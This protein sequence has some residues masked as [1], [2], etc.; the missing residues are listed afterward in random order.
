MKIKLNLFLIFCLCLTQ[1]VAQNSSV[2]SFDSFEIT[3]PSYVGLYDVSHISVDTKQSFDLFDK[4]S[5]NSSLY[6]AIYFE[7]L[8]FFIAYSA[9]TYNFSE[10]G[11]FSK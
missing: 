9:S 1:S 4:S 8:N 6:G 3:N 10:V 11:N 5:N 2:I 7:N